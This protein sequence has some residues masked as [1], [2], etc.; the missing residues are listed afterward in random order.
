MVQ[1]HAAVVQVHAVDQLI[2][3]LV[4]LHTAFFTF[5]HRESLMGHQNPD[6]KAAMPRS[7]PSY[8]S[9]D[10]PAFV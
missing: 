10:W 3:L 8:Y 2:V 5:K 1:L 9:F 4:L 6:L 7:H